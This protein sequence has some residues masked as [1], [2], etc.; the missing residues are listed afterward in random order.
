MSETNLNEYGPV[1]YTKAAK[2]KP[3]R[4]RY[5]MAMI[6]RLAGDRNNFIRVLHPTGDKKPGCIA[7]RN[8]YLYGK[9]GEPSVTVRDFIKS[10]P[11][12]DGGVTR[13]RNSLIWDLERSYIVIQGLND[14][15]E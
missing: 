2:A 5:T 15:T 11:L 9:L 6:D 3:E 7:Q 1:I 8:Y 13:A 10:Y 12:Q 14:E 4:K